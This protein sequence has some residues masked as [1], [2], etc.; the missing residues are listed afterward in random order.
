MAAQPFTVLKKGGFEE[1]VGWGELS[2]TLWKGA[3]YDFLWKSPA[4]PLVSEEK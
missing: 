2:G 1:E 3:L 4:L